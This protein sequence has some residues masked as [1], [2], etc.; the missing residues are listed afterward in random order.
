MKKTPITLIIDDSA[1]FISTP[2]VNRDPRVTGDGRPLVE[3]VPN[4]QLFNFCDIIE[5]H[6]IKGKFSIVP[7][8]GNKGDIISGFEG[9]E[10]SEVDAWIDCVRTRLY[11]SFSIC[12]E[13]LSHCKAVDI[14]T[15]KALA[16]REDEW[17]FKQDRTTLTPY[18]EKAFE[19][20]KA[21]GFDS[22]GTT[23]PWLFGKEVENEYNIAISDALY[24]VYGYK[25]AY[26]FLHSRRNIPNA[27]PWIA[28]EN[29]DRTVVSIPATV[30]DHF[31]QTMD[32]P[33]TGE[34]LIKR[35]ADAYISEDGKSGDVIKALEL[36]AYPILCTHWQSLFS[37]G[38]FTGLA[39]LDEVGK[40]IKEHLSDRVEWVSFEDLLNEVVN[41]KEQYRI[42]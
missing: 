19:L 38:L 13:I 8:A 30:Y 26:Y 39:A 1:P 4:S 6:G 10:K 22:H 18:I 2:Y 37:N 27:K 29:G 15:G 24:N 14:K 3:F 31:W 36:G 40:R 35:V 16:E 12:P 11:P 33:E 9:T 42:S 5:R 28:Y 23:S 34:A 41:N 17:S 21:A 32:T 20:I 7:M 25:N